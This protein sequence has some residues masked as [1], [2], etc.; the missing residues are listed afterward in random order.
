M[1]TRI[2]ADMPPLEKVHSE[3]EFLREIGYHHERGR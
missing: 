3:N 1:S 2:Q